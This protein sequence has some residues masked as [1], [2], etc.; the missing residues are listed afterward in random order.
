MN[1]MNIH[2]SGGIGDHRMAAIENADFHCLI[3]GD[4]GYE[5]HADIF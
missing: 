2:Q 5:L 3:R 1:E 4:I